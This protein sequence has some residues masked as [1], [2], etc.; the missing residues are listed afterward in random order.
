MIFLAKDFIYLLFAVL[1]VIIVLLVRKRQWSPIAWLAA[2]LIVCFGL[3][4]VAAQF[5]F[6]RRPF[7]DHKLTQLVAHAG[8]SS[9]PSDHTTAAVAIAL[10]LIVFTVYKKIGWLFLVAALL[11]G[12]ARVFVGIHYP[13][14]IIGGFITAGVG[15]GLVYVVYRIVETRKSKELV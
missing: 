1:A 15:T 5:H 4:Q 8:G 12:F 6:D 3:L 11:I 13:L 9:F 10:G 7:M 14:D 2:N